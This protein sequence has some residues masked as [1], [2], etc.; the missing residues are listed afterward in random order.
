M[1]TYNLT[2][3]CKE[4]KICVKTHPCSK[5]EKPKFLQGY[6]I[7]ESLVPTEMYQICKNN[8]LRIQCE[9]KKKSYTRIFKDASKAK[10]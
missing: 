7:S 8:A 3:C 1:P 4:V 10:R 6:E 9:N 5:N 2:A